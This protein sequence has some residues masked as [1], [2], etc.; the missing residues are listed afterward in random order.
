M[1]ACASRYIIHNVC[2][3]CPR[4]TLIDLD[5]QTHN[6]NK[7]DLDDHLDYRQARVTTSPVLK[8][9]DSEIYYYNYFWAPQSLVIWSPVVEWATE[10]DSVAT[11]TY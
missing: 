10:V 2:V 3:Q 9:G 8:E 6:K 7:F 5:L 4:D 1:V 11:V